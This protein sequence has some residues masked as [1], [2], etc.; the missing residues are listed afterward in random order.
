MGGAKMDNDT[1]K[2]IWYEVFPNSGIYPSKACLG[3][4][5]FY[6]CTLGNGRHEAT[7]GIIE[8]DALHYLFNISEN[9]YSEYLHHFYIK[10]SRLHYC[11]DAVRLRKKNIKNITE[12]KLKKRF[13]EIKNRLIENKD[14]FINLQYNINDKI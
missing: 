5:F 4:S 8:N 6:R 10:P 11:Y 9:N 14:N 12:E 2:K 3:D 7:N 1:I 13:I